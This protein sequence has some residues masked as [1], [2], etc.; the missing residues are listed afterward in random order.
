MPM[1]ICVC[2]IVYV[3]VPRH[4]LVCSLDLPPSVLCRLG[5]AQCGLTLGGGWGCM[6]CEAMVGGGAGKGLRTRGCLYY[7]YVCL[8]NLLPLTLVTVLDPLAAHHGLTFA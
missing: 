6:A 5:V 1:C 7:Y 4:D 3:S 2:I 8:T